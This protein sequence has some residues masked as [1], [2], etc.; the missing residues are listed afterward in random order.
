MD[1]MLAHGPG[2]FAVV[3][4]ALA[5]AGGELFVAFAEGRGQRI[6]RG[7]MLGYAKERVEALP[8]VEQLFFAVRQLT[9][10]NAEGVGGDA[11]MEAA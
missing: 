6:E 10:D 11:G 9:T 7:G 3:G 4:V 1:Y 8:F 5:D 2:K